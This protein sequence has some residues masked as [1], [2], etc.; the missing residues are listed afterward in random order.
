MLEAS[1]IFTKDP[2]CNWFDIY[3]YAKTTSALCI[4][5]TWRLTKAMK[6]LVTLKWT[7]W[8]C[9]QSC[10]TICSSLIYSMQ[11]YSI[12]N[13]IYFY[14]DIFADSIDIILVSRIDSQLH[15][16]KCFGPLVY[17]CLC[18]IEKILFMIYCTSMK[19][20]PFVL[21]T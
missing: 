15:L 4:V 18:F 16:V 7:L 2:H 9:I 21:H 20:F 3:I 8:R 14:R 6:A 11:M 17:C 12:S 5:A 13:Y 19:D 10:W 1:I